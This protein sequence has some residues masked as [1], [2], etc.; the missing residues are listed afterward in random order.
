MV[1]Q[2]YVPKSLQMFRLRDPISTLAWMAI[3]LTRLEPCPAT[4]RPTAEHIGECPL[5]Y[6]WLMMVGV[7]PILQV[8]ENQTPYVHALASQLDVFA[9]SHV[10]VATAMIFAQREQS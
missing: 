5:H 1:F 8:L 6:D 10:G 2:P 4:A 9:S 7:A 3:E